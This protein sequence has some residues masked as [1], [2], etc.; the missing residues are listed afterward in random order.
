MET[1]VFSRRAVLIG[2]CVAG[3]A[4]LAGRRVFGQKTRPTDL[5]TRPEIR[6]LDGAALEKF[7]VAF[8]KL[9]DKDG[10]GGYQQLAGIHGYPDNKCK[11]YNDLFLAWHR[12]Y[13][14]AFE[15][16]LRAIDPTVSLPYWDW[17]SED[18]IKEGLPRAFA[19]R[20]CMIGGKKVDNPLYSAYNPRTK[21]Q[22]RRAPDDPF[23]L[24]SIADKVQATFSFATYPD[25]NIKL[26][27][28]PHDDLHAWVGGDMSRQID[29]A[30][31][32]VFWAHHANVDRQWAQWQAGVNNDDPSPQLMKQPLD[33]FGVTVGGV[34]DYKTK[35]GY[36]YDKAPPMPPAVL[37]ELSEGPVL[38]V[39]ELKV[40]AGGR[41][42]FLYVHGLRPSDDSFFIHVFVNQPKADSKTALQGNPAYAGSFGIFAGGKGHAHQP[43]PRNLR[44]LD[45]TEALRKAKGAVSVTLVASDSERKAVPVSKLPF[46]GVSVQSE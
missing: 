25:F 21:T 23:A 19:E 39:K 5:V 34:I 36:Q 9:K 30:F 7:R 6:S 40:L 4:L 15:K 26:E 41:R 22:T 46:K 12:A 28:P 33:P 16:A 44:A 31:D 1:Q 18:S 32:P 43:P 35:L 17:T 38:K 10:K 37:L 14:S 13:L 29:A 3:G 2:G 11:H 42:V 20:Q 24:Q 8:Q 45:I 27:V